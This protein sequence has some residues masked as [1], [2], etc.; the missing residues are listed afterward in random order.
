ML[1]G[2]TPLMSVREPPYEKFCIRHWHQTT[3]S[4]SVML[5]TTLFENQT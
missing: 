2:A 1:T 3:N 5:D 4:S